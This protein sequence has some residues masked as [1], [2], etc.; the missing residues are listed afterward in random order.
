MVSR[1]FLCFSRSAWYEQGMTGCGFRW[2][3]G[4]VLPDLLPPTPPPPR[5]PPPLPPLPLRYRVLRLARSLLPF[6]PDT[7]LLSFLMGALS[8]LLTLIT[9]S[10]AMMMMMVRMVVMLQ[11]GGGGREGVIEPG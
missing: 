8:D 6:R 9:E 4:G 2:E 3:G 5:P 10:M 11:G 7:Q 1:S